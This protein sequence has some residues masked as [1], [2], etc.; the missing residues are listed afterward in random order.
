MLLLGNALTDSDFKARIDI[1]VSEIQVICEVILPLL[2]SIHHRPNVLRPR[3][4][5]ILNFSFH[6]EKQNLALKFKQLFSSFEIPLPAIPQ[7]TCVCA[8]SFMPHGHSLSVLHVC[9]RTL[10][11]YLRVGMCGFHDNGGR[12]APIKRT[13]YV[14]LKK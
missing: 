7:R 1:V 12:G 14:K 6:S 8:A 4:E 9:T 11:L 10:H 5:Q 13:N 2:H 3:R